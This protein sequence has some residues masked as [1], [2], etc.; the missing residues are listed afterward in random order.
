MPIDEPFAKY[1]YK[2]DSTIIPPG[3]PKF[4]ILHFPFIHVIGG[5]IVGAQIQNAPPCYLSYNT[6][7]YPR[8]YPNFHPSTSCKKQHNPFEDSYPI[9]NQP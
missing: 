6:Q 5:N 1:C 9:L 8:R 2:K 7:P 3:P 4:G